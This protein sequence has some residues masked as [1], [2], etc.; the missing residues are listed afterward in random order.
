M[1]SSGQ[2]VRKQTTGASQI[3]NVSKSLGLENKYDMGT[4]FSFYETNRKQVLKF[5]RTRHSNSRTVYVGVVHAL[6]H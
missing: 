1:V 5:S 2:N 4:D 3:V 6:T